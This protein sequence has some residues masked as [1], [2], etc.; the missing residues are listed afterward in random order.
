MTTIKPRL[1]RPGDIV[2]RGPLR[3]L[4][5]DLPARGRALAQLGSYE[6]GGG[7]IRHIDDMFAP[8]DD[9]PLYRGN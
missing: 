8:N 7:T 3:F 1:V 5:I 9:V 2:E 4:V 6:Q